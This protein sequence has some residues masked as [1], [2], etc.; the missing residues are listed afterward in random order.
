M[1]QIN[2]M[3]GKANKVQLPWY[4]VPGSRDAFIARARPRR[5]RR[6]NLSGRDDA[7]VIP[8]LHARESVEEKSTSKADASVSEE[9]LEV[10]PSAGEVTAVATESQAHSA[11]DA[12]S[13]TSTIAAP[14]EPET[15]AT[16]QAPSESDFAPVST[17]ATPAQATQTSPKPVVP[18]QHARSGTRTAIAVPNIPGLPKAKAASPPSTAGRGAVPKSDVLEPEPKAEDA[19]AGEAASAEPVVSEAPAVEPPKPAA[20]KSWA[21]LM[22]S[23]KPKTAVGVANGQMVPNGIQ[24]PKTAPLADALRQY[25]VQSDAKLA[26]LEPRGLVNTGNMC[27]M[28]SVCSNSVLSSMTCMLTPSRFFKFWF[29]ARLSTTFWTRSESVLFTR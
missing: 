3:Y 26:F 13:E 7:V 10:Q 6:R 4:S 8:E 24:L 22:K 11:E 18:Q 15:P 23:N 20:P 17:P 28:N 27:Y 2:N 5:R 19:V 21:D 14:S 9:K 29:S 25:S 16:S 12:S 1:S